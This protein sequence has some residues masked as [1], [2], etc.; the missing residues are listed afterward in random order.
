MIEFSDKEIIECLRSRQSYVVRY[1]SDR[2]LPMIRLMVT[3]MGGSTEDAKDIFQDGLI[4]MLEKID[5]NQLVLTC[6]FKTFFYSVCENLWKKVLEKRR[7]A[8]NYFN[9]RIETSSDNDFTETYDNQLYE[10]IFY[11][12]FETLDNVSKEILKLNWQ[13][14]SPMEIAEK[15]GYTYGYVRKKKCECQAELMKRVTNH[16]NYKLIKKTEESIMQGVCNLR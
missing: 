9:R 7:A 15:L 13:E 1:L 3:Q 12:V 14:F 8:A 2:Y 6:K 16:P 11:E 10:N 5:T 4:I